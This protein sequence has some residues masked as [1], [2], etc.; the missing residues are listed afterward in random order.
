V[1]TG[2]YC[3]SFLDEFTTEGKI[4]IVV[5]PQVPSLMK[6]DR[7]QGGMVCLCQPDHG[8]CPL[9]ETHLWVCLRVFSERVQLGGQTYLEFGSTVL[10]A[11]TWE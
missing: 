3:P 7:S 4:T 11:R 6:G 8:C 1:E 2:D 10:W 9:G 5:S